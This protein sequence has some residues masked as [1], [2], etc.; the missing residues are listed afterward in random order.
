MIPIQEHLK[1]VAPVSLFSLIIYLPLLLMYKD[2]YTYL[3]FFMRVTASVS[4]AL[5]LISTTK[6][7]EIINLMK[8]YKL[9]TAF[10]TILYISYL[11]LK[12]ISR[13][14]MRIL[15]ARISRNIREDYRT[16]WYLLSTAVA[17]FYKRVLIKS[18]KLNLAIAA[19]NIQMYK[20]K[21]YK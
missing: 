21:K 5:T 2:V 7:I 13:E 20:Y 14:L 1:R 10:S 11:Y 9:L 12:V 8:R 15:F 4:L 19:R 6:F 16:T 3:E 17:T 18:E